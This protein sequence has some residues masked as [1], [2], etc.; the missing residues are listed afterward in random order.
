MHPECRFLRTKGKIYRNLIHG[1]YLVIYRITTERIEVLNVIHGSR[2][3]STI[4]SSRKI[5]ID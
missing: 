5:R 3:V 2:S 4:K 1:N